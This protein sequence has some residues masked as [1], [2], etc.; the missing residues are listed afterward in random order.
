MMLA[1][2]EKTANIDSEVESLAETKIVQETYTHCEL[3][4]SEIFASYY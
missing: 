2:H 4:V 3:V 1:V